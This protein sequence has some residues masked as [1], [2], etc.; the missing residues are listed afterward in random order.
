MNQNPAEEL[1]ALVDQDNRPLGAVT[2]RIM[3]QQRLIHRATYILVFNTEGSLFIQKR[4][5][6]KDI[7]PGYWDIAAGGVVL[8]E[9]D[10]EAAA[11]RELHEELG[12]KGKA[13]D[14]LFDH[15]FEDEANR[16]W[17]RIYTCRHNG[18]FILQREE[19]DY[20]RFLPPAEVTLLH[21]AEPVTPDGLLI[22]ERVLASK[23]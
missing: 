5:K 22:L 1:V 4:S 7:Y 15:Y 8:A 2:R 16:V 18:P 10:Y 12:I 14:P 19:I 3:R 13:L 9:E 11:L 23:R 20:G 21:Q 17:G 6:T